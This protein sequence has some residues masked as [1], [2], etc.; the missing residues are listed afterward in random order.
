MDQQKEKSGRR[1]II[2]G[3]HT[4]RTNRPDL[5]QPNTQPR[6]LEGSIFAHGTTSQIKQREIRYLE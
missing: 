3:K 5:K 4:E 6:D 1:K 2:K